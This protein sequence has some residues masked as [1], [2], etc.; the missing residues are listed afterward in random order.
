M[1]KLFFIL[2]LISVAILLQAQVYSEIPPVIT[3]QPQSVTAAAGSVTNLSLVYSGSEA[4]IKWMKDGQALPGA[5]DN[6]NTTLIFSNVQPM[7]IGD[8]QAIVSNG[9]GS[10]TSSVASL[11]I[12]GVNSALWQGLVAYYPLNGNANDVV[13]TN[14]GSIQGGAGFTNGVSGE[15]LAFTNADAAVFIPASTSLDVG[16]GAG[17]TLSVWIKPTDITQGYPLFEWNHSNYFGYWA[18]WGVHFWCA[19]GQPTTGSAGPGGPGQLYANILD[20]SY[21]WHQLGSAGGVVNSNGFQHVVLTYDSSSGVATIYYNGQIVS[22]ANL[23]SFIPQTSYDLYLGRRISDGGVFSG[24][25]DE[26]M[27]FS[28]ALTA[29]EVSELYLS[30]VPKIGPAIVSQPLSVTNTVGDTVALSV[31]ATGSAPLIYQ[32]YKEGAVLAVG[33]NATLLINGAQQTDS[34]NYSVVITN[35]YGSVTSS[36]A[37]LIVNPPPFVPLSFVQSGTLGVGSYPRAVVSMDLNGDGKPDLISNGDYG[38]NF[39]TNNGQGDFI[40]AGTFN[41][42]NIASYTMSMIATDVNLDGKLDLILSYWAGNK[43]NILTNNGSGGFSVSS[44]PIVGVAPGNVAAADVNG[45]EAI[46]LIAANFDD[47]TLSVLTNNGSGGFSFKSTLQVGSGPK[48]VCAADVNGA[49]K[50]DLLTVNFYDN[51]VSVVTNSDGA[52][53]ASSYSFPVG[54]N[55]SCLVANDFNQDGKIDLIVAN[56]GDSTASVFTNNGAGKFALSSTVAT[57][58]GPFGIAVAD[59]NLDGKRDFVTVNR[60]NSTVTVITNDG[61]AGM[62]VAFSLNVGAQPQFVL[63]TDVNQDLRPD[64]IAVNY[65]G[66]SISILTNKTSFNTVKAQASVIFNHLAQAYTGTAR[67]VMASTIPTNLAVSLSYNGSGNAPTNAGSYTVIGIINDADYQGSATN[68]LVISPAVPEITQAPTVSSITY[69]QTLA[70]S[71]LSNGVASTPGIFTFTTPNI[72]PNAGTTN[73]SVTFTPSNTNDY[74]GVTTNITVAVNKAVRTVVLSNL[75]QVYNGTA[76]VVTVTTMPTNLAVALTYNDSG[77]APTNG[78]SYTVIGTINDADYQGSATNTLLISPALPEIT[79]APTASAIIYG[80]TLASSILSNGVASTPG[81]FSFTSPSLAPNAG[82]T[83]VSVTFTPSNTNDYTGASTNVTVTVTKAFGTVV[84]SNMVQV[85]NGTAGVVAATTTP[86]NLAVVLTYNGSSN[87]PTNAGSYTVIGTINDAN[88]QGSATNTLMID[89]VAAV[90][91]LGNLNQ[92]YDGAAKLVNVITYPPGLAV[93]FKYNGFVNAPTNVGSYAA[94]GTINDVNYQGSATNTLVIGKAT[95]LVILGS[96]NQIYDGT[97]KSV[98]ATTVPSGLTVNFT[99]N[100]S[101]NAPA[102]AGSYTVIGN[103]NDA[104]YAGSTTNAFTIYPAGPTILQQPTNQTVILGATAIFNVVAVGAIPLHYQWR[105]NGVNIASATNTTLALYNVSTKAG[106]GYSVIITNFSGSVTSSL[107]QLTVVLQQAPLFL[108]KTG[109]GTFKGATNSQKL[110]VGTLYKMSAKPAKG[111]VFKN[112]ED[113]LGNQLTNKTKL[114]FLMRSNLS[115]TANFIETSHPKLT[116]ISPVKNAQLNGNSVGIIGTT[117]DDWAVTNVTYSVNGGGWNSAST[118]N[119]YSNWTATVALAAGTNTIRV[120]AQNR[121]GLSSLTNSL[122]VIV[123]NVVT[124]NLV[125]NPQNQAPMQARAMAVAVPVNKGFTF[126]LELSAGVPGHIEY[127]TD[128]V[129]WTTWTNFDGSSTLL[130]FNDPQA[131]ESRRF[132]R[133]VTP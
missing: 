33:T 113:G 19:P 125:I 120:F 55:P 22:Q 74:T 79:Q 2:A 1:K 122:N 40:N 101:S 93:A 98:T 84:L 61:L 16:K 12:P 87:A 18:P 124:L 118:A 123:T 60:N 51:T 44:S 53:F 102:N 43:I 71:T 119:N 127:S 116:I 129:H 85:Y 14:N 41:D 24:L 15:S 132:Y 27:V 34:G 112:W 11:S 54:V 70:S 92:T 82:T 4:L 94:T 77:D 106:V 56:Y 73:V 121:G 32:W 21:N 117:S 89:K 65:G 91:T 107:A 25:M 26:A 133:A 64:I 100:E 10:V 68:T 7:N 47:S 38:L 20:E 37:A 105:S 42:G 58:A 52:L 63:S 83:N 115:L 50:V 45:D 86:T 76:R 80:Q 39:Q 95:G 103:I 62:A 88:Y 131:V 31:T 17:L 9:G 36:V 114:T 3:T 28:R 126:S 99:Y 29:S 49:G 13:G 46:D 72:A 67:E 8:Y 57:G 78:G 108:N 104:N 81:T 75:V 110:V 35:A 128:L 109:L 5:I 30:E 6:T 96:L 23:G 48:W 66:G 130:Q 59:F 111:F 97:S 69:G 90:V